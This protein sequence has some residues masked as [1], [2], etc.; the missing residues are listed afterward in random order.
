MKRYLT[1]FWSIF[2]LLLMLITVCSLVIWFKPEWLKIQEQSLLEKQWAFQCYVLA[3][4]VLF[5]LI[6]ILITRLFIHDARI[7][8]HCWRKQKSALE[9]VSVSPE[10]AP[11]FQELI[12]HLRCRYDFF[13][14][15]KVRILM[16]I[17]EPEQVEAIAPGLTTQHWL[18][19]HDTVLLWGGSPQ[20]EPDSV[21]LKALRKLRRRR[22]L[23]GV[24]W[25]MTEEQLS[26]R[27]QMDTALRMLQKQGRQLGWQAPVYVWNVRH[28]NW[29]QRDR[30][31]QT[32]GCLLPEACT[33]QALE[34]SLNQLPPQL[35]ARG[36]GQALA[37]NRHDFLLR[38]AQYMLAGG[39]ERWVR[40]LSP[41]LTRQPIWLAGVMFSL[42]LAVQPGMTEH[43]WWLMPVGTGYGKMSVTS[44]VR[45]S[46]FRG[47]RVPSGA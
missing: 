6:F 42:P 22:P 24:V 14:R 45:P 9:T 3:A 37:E 35:T 23:D 43:G 2:G 18:E 41:L 29:D 12:Y 1:L 28:S 40:H 36:I 44:G 27:P 15:F 13:W 32:I 26:Q 47:K 21:Q 11:I 31:T 16:V 19:G 39:V 25:A 4:S 34:Q 30:P 46:V 5:S 7:A 20:A 10:P 8:F 38:L 33:P 17:G